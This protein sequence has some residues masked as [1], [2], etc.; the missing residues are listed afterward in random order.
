MM[1]PY[2]SFFLSVLKHR[3]D[4]SIF[5]FIIYVANVRTFFLS[6]K[7]YEYFFLCNESK[8][9]FFVENSNIELSEACF[10]I[11][12]NYLNSRIIIGKYKVSILLIKLP[13]PQTI[14]YRYGY[15]RRQTISS[16][17]ISS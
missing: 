14:I 17:T 7:Y 1:A 15:N 8:L 12:R 11:D 16:D 3:I 2:L 6:T 13:L 4:P 9:R 10:N 5:I